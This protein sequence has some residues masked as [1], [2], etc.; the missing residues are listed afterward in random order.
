[1]LKEGNDLFDEEMEIRSIFSKYLVLATENA[2]ETIH[3]IDFNPREMKVT[4]DG[5]LYRVDMPEIKR[6]LHKDDPYEKNI[7]DERVSEAT[8]YI[9][10][11]DSKFYVVDLYSDDNTSVSLN[12]YERLEDLGYRPYEDETMYSNNIDY[13]RPVL[14]LEKPLEVQKNT[15][16][17]K[18]N[19][20]MAQ[21]KELKNSTIEELQREVDRSKNPE[22]KKKL[23][24]EISIDQMSNEKEIKLFGINGMS[25]YSRDVIFLY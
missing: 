23:M 13:E 19:P 15:L 9:L 3:S 11:E 20:A 21:L 8:V 1:F 4:K 2:G 22:W 24:E 7:T 5:S 18:E 16:M 12:K 17:S 14:G 25:R 10:P 6:I